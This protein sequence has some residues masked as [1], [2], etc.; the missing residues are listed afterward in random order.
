A[1]GT[2]ASSD[3]ARMRTPR[4]ESASSGDTSGQICAA[5][6]FAS[7]SSAPIRTIG[8]GSASALRARLIFAG[9]TYGARSVSALARAKAGAF[10]SAATTPS[11]VAA[12]AWAVPAEWEASGYF[13]PP[14]RFAPRPV[15]IGDAAHWADLSAWQSLQAFGVPILA[16]RS[17]R[18]TRKL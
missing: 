8:S 15:S 7:M 4:L 3:T 10:G 13:C 12:S 11:R 17:G 16:E 2:V 18:G 9:E 14:L 5:E 6:T 1:V